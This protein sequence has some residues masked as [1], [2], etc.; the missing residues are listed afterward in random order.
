MPV[1]QNLANLNFKQFSPLSDS[2]KGEILL[3][4]MFSH[5][6]WVSLMSSMGRDGQVGRGGQ[7][8]AGEVGEK[9]DGAGMMEARVA[10]R[11]TE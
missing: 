9:K 1:K 2:D 6:D 4:I 3:K 7:A 11:M 8:Q 5:C 10:G